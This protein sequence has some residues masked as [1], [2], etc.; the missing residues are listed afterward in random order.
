MDFG[1]MTQK[2]ELLKPGRKSIRVSQ[3]PSRSPLDGDFVFNHPDWR[4]QQSYPPSS[5]LGS[6]YFL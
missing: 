3:L 2:T 4:I 6:F 5:R 1:D